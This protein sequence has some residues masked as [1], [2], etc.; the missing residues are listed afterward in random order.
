MGSNAQRVNLL[1]YLRSKSQVD[2]DSLD[3][4]LF[5]ELGPFVDCTSNQ[6][7]SYLELLNP[8]RAALLK[9]SAALAQEL[10]SHYPGVPFEKLAVE[11]SVSTSEE[12]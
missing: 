9:K 4:P 8:Q 2:C 11:I 12:R 7:D 1:E 6:A 5:K 10:T 3:I